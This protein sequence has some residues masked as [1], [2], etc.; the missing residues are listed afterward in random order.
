[1]KKQF[2]LPMKRKMN[3][4]EKAWVKTHPITWKLTNTSPKVCKAC[5]SEKQT[6]FVCSVCK[7][8]TCPGH[9]KLICES[10]G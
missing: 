4:A 8:G 7:K 6:P 10:C 5:K 2:T 1:M 9:S 3:R